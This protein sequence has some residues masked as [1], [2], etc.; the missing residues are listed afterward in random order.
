MKGKGRKK[1]LIKK[2]TPHPTSPS[3]KFDSAHLTEKDVRK[4]EEK[5]VGDLRVVDYKRVFVPRQHLIYVRRKS[6]R[7][8]PKTPRLRR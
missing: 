8:T 5:L 7:I 3:Y 2:G 4:T 1:S 6:P